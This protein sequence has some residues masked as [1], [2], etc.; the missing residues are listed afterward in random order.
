MRRRIQI[1][2]QNWGTTQ[3]KAVKCRKQ[4]ENHKIAGRN[5]RCEKIPSAPITT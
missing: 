2:A 5:K 1:R 3:R 4:L